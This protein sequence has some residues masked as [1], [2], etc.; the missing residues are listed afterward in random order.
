MK[1]F[2]SSKILFFTAA[3]CFV[4]VIFL[5]SQPIFACSWDYLIW[6]NRS[7][8]SD[9]YYRFVK[10]DKAGFIDQSGKVVIEPTLWLSGNYQ[11]GV[12]N[13]LLRV[14]Y[15]KYI[16]LKTDEELSEEYYELNTQIFDGLSVKRF[17]NKYGYIDR[18]GETIIKP[19]FVY[20]KNFSN[21][22]A[23]VVVDGPCL[24]DSKSPCSTGADI[25]PYGTA[26]QTN[27]TC[28]FN[29][30]N[31]QGKIISSQ[32]FLDIGDFSEG[33]APVKTSSGWGYIDRKGNLV[34][35]PQFTEADSF[36]D[37]LALVEKDGLFG[38]IN[39]FGAIVIEPQFK[40][41]QSFSNGLA[42]V[43]DYGDGTGKSEFYYI[44]KNGKTAFPDK[45]LLA[46]NYF[47]GLAHVLVSR[48]FRV[49]KKDNEELEIRKHTFAYINE[50]GK[51][52]FTY[53]IDDEM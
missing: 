31:K 14:D 11:D 52:V 1:L 15:E 17:E 44:N 25:L 38:Y 12:I 49:E 9:P 4:A 50:K 16:N 30:I 48:T 43:G 45:F 8:N 2:P 21:G 53:E 39:S 3:F 18:K 35:S 28:K 37:G 46:S 47:K 51:K 13:G 22:L 6:E 41:A 29:F 23:P 33:L 32:T 10:D 20:A 27:E 7:E 34:I 40:D 19:K 36:S 42:V 24:Y 5:F 26:S